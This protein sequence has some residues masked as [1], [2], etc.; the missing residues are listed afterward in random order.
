M[1]IQLHEFFTSSGVRCQRLAIIAADE[2]SPRNEAH[3]NFIPFEHPKEDGLH[4]GGAQAI[5]DVGEHTE[6]DARTSVFGRHPHI[7]Q[8][9]LIGRSI[10]PT[11][12][13]QKTDRPALTNT[14]T[15]VSSDKFGSPLILAER[16][17]SF[18]C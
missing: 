11:G 8:I 13:A 16:L 7:F 14:D 17:F 5:K 15:P 2:T 10:G 1:N 18:I 9:T 3:C 4:P 12:S 6:C